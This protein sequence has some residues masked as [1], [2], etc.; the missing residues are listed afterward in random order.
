MGHIYYI[1]STH[2]DGHKFFVHNSITIFYT[3]TLKI[4]KAIDRTPVV[5]EE[6]KFNQ[7]LPLWV[8]CVKIIFP[9]KSQSHLIGIFCKNHVDLVIGF[10][11]SRS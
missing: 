7:K 6:P 11:E 9:I 2:T 5:T 8:D 3:F 4:L 10:Y 1:A